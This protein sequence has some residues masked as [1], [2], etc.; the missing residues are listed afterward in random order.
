MKNRFAILAIILTLIISMTFTSVY[1]SVTYSRGV[2]A[3]GPEFNSGIL[4]GVAET[5]F[6][7]NNNATFN[8]YANKGFNIIRVPVLWERIQPALYAALNTT[9][10]NG[11]KSNITWA[12]SHNMQVIIDIH[13]YGR[14][15][16]NII[17]TA[18]CSSADFNDLWVRLSN[19]FKN[20]TGVYSYDIMNEP[21]DMGTS[22]W[23]ALS[24]AVVTAIRNNGDNKLIMVE[25]TYWAN[26]QGWQSKNGTA[27]SWITDPANNFMYSAHCYFDFNQSGTYT[28]TYD[29][30]LASNPDLANVGVKRVMDFITWCNNNNVRGFI[31]EYGVPN[32]D[33]RWNVVLDNFLNTLDT[34]GFDATYW[35]GGTWWGSYPLSCQPT[36]NYTTDA[37]QMSVLLNHLGGTVT[38]PTPTPTATPTPQAMFNPIADTFA[39]NGT[40]QNNNY[41]S[42]T[43]IDLKTS[44]SGNYRKGFLKFD[45]SS[46]GQPIKSAKLRI[47]GKNCTDSS[48]VN[49]GAYQIID[50]S[51]EESTTTWVN[52]SAMSSLINSVNVNNLQ[53]YYEIDVTSFVLEEMAGDK[54]ISIGLD[55]ATSEKNLSFSSK[56]ALSNLPE[57][58]L[59]YK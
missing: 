13:N 59:E 58:L 19:E 43:T 8:Y 4:P 24:Q 1:A 50:D 12:K 48:S 3:A 55:C 10:L 57:L 18:G 35:A 49:V 40:Y 30:E 31:G 32:N 52:A 36:N 47:Y 2:N 7:W 15:R 34:Y 37:P 5:N 56:E 14:Y 51:W 6:T 39:R 22:D 27:T 9:Y 44:G 28:K 54:V 25:G 26:A 33:S 38:P 29:Q 42:T 11:L 20:E 46:F 53:K 23:K 41:G 17:G 45:V 16:G 21:H